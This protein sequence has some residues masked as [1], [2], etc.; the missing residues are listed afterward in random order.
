MFSKRMVKHADELATSVDPDQTYN[1]SLVLT[2]VY[3]SDIFR[4]NKAY[5]KRSFLDLETFSKHN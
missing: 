5:V 4:V 1:W 3:L 2:Q